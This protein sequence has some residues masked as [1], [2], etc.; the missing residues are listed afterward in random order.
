M[1][2][3]RGNSVV[4]TQ[5][6]LLSV[7]V[8][9]GAMAS[10]A[11]AAHHHSAGF[12]P[13]DDA[14]EGGASE[15]VLPTGGQATGSGDSGSFGD[16]GATAPDTGISAECPSGND[17]VFVA[18]EEQKLYSFDPTTATFTLLGLV[19]CAGGQYVNSMAIDRAGNAWINYGDGSLW[20]SPTQNPTCVSTGYVPL[21]SGVSLFGMGFSAK[22]SGG[23]TETLYIDDLAGGGLGYIDLSSMSLLR[24]GPFAGDLANRD[25]ELTGTG[26]AR[27]F[28]FFAGSYLGDGGSASVTQIDPSSEGAMK[29]WPLPT[30]DTGSD[31]AFA[32]WGG[33]FYLFTADKYNENDP[34]TTVTKLDPST[35]NLTV[36]AQNIGFRVVGA[37][38][39]T[40][41]PL[42][43]P[44]Q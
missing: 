44:N 29:T 25:C 32:F 33:D 34:Y 24:F 23:T 39:S 4:K 37:G 41:A 5:R 15:G 31:W 2:A 3:L 20:K 18:T 1:G 35:G 43:A 30:I 42:V 38:V 36:M 19:D 21:Q 10:N 12:E 40:C 7:F 26:D 22:T 8:A 13:G 14:G 27:L 11:C 17:L 28:G 16:A 9:L 6:V